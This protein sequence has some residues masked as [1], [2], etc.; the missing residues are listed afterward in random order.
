[1]KMMYLF[2]KNKHKIKVA[3]STLFFSLPTIHIHSK[4]QGLK[5]VSS[6][7]MESFQLFSQEIYKQS[8]PYL[9]T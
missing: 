7:K 1:M 2:P 9:F 8:L 3:I 5:C 6:G 4:F